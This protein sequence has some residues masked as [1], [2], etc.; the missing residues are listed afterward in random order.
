MIKLLDDLRKG[1]KIKVESIREVDRLEVSGTMEKPEIYVW[2]KI[3]CVE[4]GY[5]L[6][7]V[8]KVEE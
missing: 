4:E 5:L 8:K 3:G 1:D 6:S 2:C 7:K